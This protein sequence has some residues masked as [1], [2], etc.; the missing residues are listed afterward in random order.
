M[1]TFQAREAALRGVLNA[2]QESI[3]LF[4]ADGILRLANETALTRF[5]MPAEKVIGKHVNDILPPDLATS[6]MMHLNDVVRTGNPAEFEDMRAGMLFRHTLSPVFDNRGSVTD[7]AIYSRDITRQR[8]YE[9]R[10]AYLASFPQLDPNPIIEADMAGTVTFANPAAY[11]LLAR[12]GLDSGETKAFVPSDLNTILEAWDRKSPSTVDRE[13]TIADRLFSTSV[14]LDPGFD[15]ARIYAYDSTERKQAEDGLRKGLERFEILSL[16]AG[17]LLR[18]TAPQTLV[19]SLCKRVMAHLDCHAFF[20]YLVD[21]PTGRLRLNACAG[22]PEAEARRI[23]WLERGIAVCG[24]VARDG[25]R[26][27]AECIQTTPDE[28]TD[29]VRSYGI[30]AYACHPILGSDGKVMGTLSFGTKSRDAFTE[31]DLSLMQAVT[32]QVA[33]AMIRMSSEQEL[34]TNE[35]KYRLLFGNM[36]EGFALYELLYDGSG[37]PVDWRVLEV[38]DAYVHH[39]GISRDRVVGRRMSEI[40]PPAIPEYLPRFAEVVAARK[41]VEFD[42]YSKLTQRHHHVISFPAGP[43]RFA[44]TVT[45]IT[46]RKLA[47]EGLKEREQKYRTL[48]DRMIDGFALHEIVLDASG[49]PRDYRFLEVNRAFER[50]TGLR[51]ADIIGQCV[52]QVLPDIRESDFDW[53]GA[54]GKVALTGEELRIEQYSEELGKWYSITAYS[55]QK[56]FFATIFEDITARKKAEDAV[57]LHAKQL[58][59]RNEEL[60]RFNRVAVDRELRMIE[61]KKEINAALAAAGRPRRYPLA[62]EDGPE[63]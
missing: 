15:A 18:T 6:R 52:T 27:V 48:I 26:I 7:V 21:A 11:H 23:E 60:A 39:T 17:G 46:E 28:R 55:P 63:A 12:L 50:L 13:V 47:E 56:G 33:V 40:F 5:G 32:D 61:L 45:D 35:E 22:I 1:D 43:H 3:L 16:V 8:D 53:I 51:G 58:A 41:T 20:N 37:A 62:F 59:E 49:L 2:T 42:T 19:E 10:L 44:N 14:H 29:L 54:Y 31:D 9:E 30:R 25:S 4:S 38:N 34:R 57:K 24:C 36:G